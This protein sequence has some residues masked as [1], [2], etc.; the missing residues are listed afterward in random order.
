MGKI[1]F[2]VGK[3]F[4]D[5]EFKGPYEGLRAAGHQIEILGIKAGERLEGKLGKESV[6]IDAAAKD[7]DARNYDA[8]VIP[9][10][11]SPDDLRA[12]DDVAR[13]VRAFVATGLPIAAICHGPQLLIDADALRG[14]KITSWKSIRRD[15]E[16]AGATW[17]DEAVVID[18]ALITSRK[19]EDV[20]A[21]T[22]ALVERLVTLEP[23]VAG[24]PQAATVPAP[25]G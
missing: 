23:L 1:A 4:Q 3:D 17:V 9:G 2:L 12:D 5:A 22:Q 7:R 21:F 19:P 13:F 20:P 6:M 10:G 16:N 8:L 18:G 11:H 15:V 14:K 24:M 25:R